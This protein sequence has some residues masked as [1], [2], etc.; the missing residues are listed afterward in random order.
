VPESLHR[1]HVLRRCR[2]TIERTN[3]TI[4]LVLVSAIPGHVRGISF[5]LVEEL[6]SNHKQQGSALSRLATSDT[7]IPRNAKQR[8]S[9]REPSCGISTQYSVGKRDKAD[10]LAGCAGNVAVS[11]GRYLR[12]VQQLRLSP[13]RLRCA[14]GGDG[15]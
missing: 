12:S 3:D 14:N 11:L 6:G 1:W 15:R 2:D 7:G 8:C 9:V 5:R 13:A 4:G 10:N